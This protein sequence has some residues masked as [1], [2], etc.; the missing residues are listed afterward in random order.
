MKVCRI[1]FTLIHSLLTTYGNRLMVLV[2]A[3]WTTPYLF[4]TMGEN[5][6]S[7]FEYG[8]KKPVAKRLFI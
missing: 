6:L 4:L 3:V 2:V 5:M 1:I 7:T 8:K